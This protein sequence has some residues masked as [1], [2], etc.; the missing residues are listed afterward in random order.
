MRIKLLKCLNVEL[1]RSNEHFYSPQVVAKK[2]KIQ[3][4]I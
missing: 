2:L 4:T 1:I 3:T